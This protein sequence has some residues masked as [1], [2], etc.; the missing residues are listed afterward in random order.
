VTRPL[1]DIRELVRMLAAQAPLLAAE[2]LPNG[3]REGQEWRVGSIHGQPGRSM[4][5]HL[6]GPKAGVWCDFASGDAGDA[7]DLVAAVLYG[8]DK[9][10]AVAWARRWLGLD[11]GADP[12]DA[13]RR[14]RL[15]E[16]ALARAAEPDDDAVRRHRQRVAIALWCSARPHIAGTPVDAYL[17]A[18]AIDLAA[19][20]RQPRALRFHPALFHRP[21]GQKLPAMVAAIT[22][23]GGAH[24]ATHCTWLAQDGR[25]GRWGK[26]PVEPAKMVFGPMKGGT[27]RLWRGASGKPL[28]EAPPGDVVAIAEGIENALTVAIECPEWRVLA[29]VS[30]GNLPAIA[31][32]PQCS[33]IVLIADRDGENRETRR[34]REAAIARW[35]REGRRVRVALPPAGCKDWNEAAQAEAAR[36]RAMQPSSAGDG[37]A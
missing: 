37:A 5:V 9:R 16:R 10:Q 21:S 30:S 12:A 23:E 36:A 33:E 11:A 8:G 15:A 28:A 20:G 26:A 17:R 25:T 18:R 1:T 2:L 3:R 31:L 14:R 22:N 19:L 29:A 34:A 4:A 13:E 6:T 35:L 7:L 27:I 32:P 24:V